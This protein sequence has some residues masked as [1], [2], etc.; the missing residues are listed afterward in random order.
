MYIRLD[1]ADTQLFLTRKQQF[2]AVEANNRVGYKTD[3]YPVIFIKVTLWT[4]PFA[5]LFFLT[6]QQTCSSI[7]HV[8]GKETSQRPILSQV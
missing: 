7:P 3:S 8:K 6:S 5:D 2:C 1:S 4:R